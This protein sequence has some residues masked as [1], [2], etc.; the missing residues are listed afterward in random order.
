MSENLGKPILFQ[1]TDQGVAVLQVNR[2]GARNALNWQTQDRF[3]ELVEN[4]RHDPSLR[5]LIITGSGEKAFISGGDLKELK[6]HPEKEAGERLNRVMSGALINLR[7][8]PIPVIAAVNGDAFGGGCEI[9]A[10]C[11]LRVAGPDARFSFAQVRNGL[12]TGWGGTGYLVRLI[13][14]SRAMELLLS[15]RL[16]SAQDALQW[17]LIHRIAGTREGVLQ[18]ARDWAAELITLPKDALAATKQLVQATGAL[19]D[20]DLSEL[21]AKLFVDLWQTDNHLEA[22]QAFVEKRRPK[23]NQDDNV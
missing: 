18:T 12:V 15:G 22:L 21:E 13:G 20:A 23:F 8:L 16:F 10:A 1:I 11:D 6:Q 5:V 7:N 14:Q 17:G 19:S 2:P 9:V 3:A 4:I